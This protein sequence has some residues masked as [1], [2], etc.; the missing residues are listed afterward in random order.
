[1]GGNLISPAASPRTLS[2]KCVGLTT[3]EIASKD[4]LCVCVRARA[5]VCVCVCGCVGVCV[6]VCVCVREGEYHTM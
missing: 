4:G 1:M 5:R 2:L 3:G 6:C